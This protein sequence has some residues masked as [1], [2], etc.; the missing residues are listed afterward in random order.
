MHFPHANFLFHNNGD[1]TF[2]EVTPES[3]TENPYRSMGVAYSDYD[4]D[5]WVDFVTGDWNTDY[6]FFRDPGDEEG[7]QLA[8]HPPGRQWIGQQRRPRRTC[9]LMTTD[10]RTLM[11]EVKSGSSLGSGNDTALHFGLGKS[12]VNELSVVWPNGNRIYYRGVTPDQ[13]WTL[14]YPGFPSGIYSGGRSVY[15]VMRTA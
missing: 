2:T 4:A 15:C 6:K 5:G 7:R 8:H 1:G 12:T 3:W 14:E 13:V 9:L 10:G 11:Q